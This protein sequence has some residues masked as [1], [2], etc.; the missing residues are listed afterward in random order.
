MAE[1]DCRCHPAGAP[2]VQSGV[3]L[4]RQ[5]RR[6]ARLAAADAMAFWARPRGGA[7]VQEDYTRQ[8]PC[9][10][11]RQ[12]PARSAAGV[13]LLAVLAACAFA[14]TPALAAAGDARDSYAL[15]AGAGAADGASEAAGGRLGPAA[16]PA[17]P[18]RHGYQYLGRVE[19]VGAAR[20]GVP[21]ADLG[22]GAP[23]ARGA[24]SGGSGGSGGGAPAPQHHTVL[25]TAEGHRFTKRC[26]AVCCSL[27]PM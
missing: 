26:A 6:C 18:L 8:L 21:V 27:G 15:R 20:G 2:A 4:W 11:Q 19:F 12:A 25:V 7:A 10:R 3:R 23:S 22:A 17:A 24:G 9:R 14:V 1:P 13:T 5:D 16:G